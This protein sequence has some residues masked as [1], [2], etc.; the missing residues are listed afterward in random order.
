[1]EGMHPGNHKLTTHIN[2]IFERTQLAE[3]VGHGRNRR[4]GRTSH[5]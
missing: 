1:M 5:E 2:S 3:G 4:R